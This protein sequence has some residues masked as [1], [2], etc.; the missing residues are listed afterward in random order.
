MLLQRGAGGGPLRGPRETP[1]R[2]S[3]RGA[4]GEAVGSSSSTQKP[5]SWAMLTE[6]A[7][8]QDMEHIAE[9]DEITLQTASSPR[10]F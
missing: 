1:R 5:I 8:L 9:D 6:G 3:G 4:E 7:L 2:P 10:L